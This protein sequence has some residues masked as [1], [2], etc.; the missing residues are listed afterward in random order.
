MLCAGYTAVY[1]NHRIQMLHPVF[2]ESYIFLHL[3]RNRKADSFFININLLNSPDSLYY[4]PQGR[5]DIQNLISEDEIC[6]NYCKD[7]LIY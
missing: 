5:G 1:K 2:P 4:A 7:V 3:W 6:L